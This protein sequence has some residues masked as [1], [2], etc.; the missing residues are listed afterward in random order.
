MSRLSERLGRLHPIWFTFVVTAAAFATY[1]C[2]YAFRKPFTAATFEAVPGLWGLSY[3]AVL[4]IAQVLGYMLSKFVGIK[5]VSEMGGARRVRAILLLIGL[6]WLALLG[7]GA[8]PAPWNVPFLFLNGVPLGM[9]WGLVFSYVEG[10]RY[11]EVMGLGLCASFIFASGLVKDVGR[12]LMGMGVSEFWMPAATGAVFALPLLLAVGIL[13]QVPPPDAADEAARTARAPMD[14]PARGA[15]FR[16]F[17]PGLIL[18]ISAYTLLTAYR[19]FRDNF[20]ADIW[21][22]LR[23]AGFEIDF[24]ATETP[25]SILVLLLLMLLVLVRDNRQAF[26]INH[27]AIFLGLL[28]AGIA[29]LGFRQG[30]VSD[31]YWIL[32]TGFGTYLAYIPFNSIL[33]DRMIAT[34]RQVSNVGFLIYLAD[35]FGYLGSVAVL[36][37]KDL[38]TPEL[39]W[40]RFFSGASYALAIGGGLAMLGAWGY[41]AVQ[42]RRG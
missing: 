39:S 34:F 17:A 9:I 23:G 40:V 1:S 6:A 22:S 30:W 15:F 3:K 29:T 8:V 32:F 10:R 4:V 11:T 36:L 35:A 13:G 2:M 24:S 33:F 27:L 31:Y 19:D 12:G 14:G 21:T 5:V 38:F 37:Y 28:S 25:V 26:M 18:L 20:L 16:R 7:F 42:A 41:F